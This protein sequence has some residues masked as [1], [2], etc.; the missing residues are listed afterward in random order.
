MADK[1]R[2]SRQKMP[3]LS[4]E[5]I[6]NLKNTLSNTAKQEPKNKPKKNSIT[7]FIEQFQQDIKKL[8]EK[9]FTWEDITNTI[10]KCIGTNFLPST[11]SC[12][13]NSLTKKDNTKKTCSKTQYPQQNAQ[14][15]Q[16]TQEQPTRYTQTTTQT[17]QR[18]LKTTVNK[19][20]TPPQD[21][22]QI[23]I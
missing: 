2:R 10:N 22:D 12:V 8:K 9:N 11:I 3:D 16:R 21:E 20:T 4:T 18:P 1:K 23:N 15:T 17:T 13:Y 14:N 5:Q 7:T 19:T 6:N